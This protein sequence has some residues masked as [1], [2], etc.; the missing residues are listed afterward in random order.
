MPSDRNEAVKVEDDKIDG[1]VE[2]RK[3][4]LALNRWHRA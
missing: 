2:S 1:S 4:R 3:K